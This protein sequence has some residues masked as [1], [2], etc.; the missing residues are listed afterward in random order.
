MVKLRMQIQRADGAAKGVSLENT[1][2]GYRNIFHGLYVAFKKEGF[3]ALYKGAGLRVMFTVPAFGI[4][5]SLTEYSRNIAIA[6]GA[7][8]YFL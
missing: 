5:M 7:T 6:S 1:L 8:D 4:S 2:Y 3:L